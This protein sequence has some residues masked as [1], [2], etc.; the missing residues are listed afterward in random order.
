[1]YSD[2]S[3]LMSVYYKEKPEY[4][5]QSIDSMLNQI[6]PP[7][8]FVIVQDGTLTN[9]LESI[10]SSYETKYPNIFT[11]I[12]REENKGLGFSL[13]EGLKACRNE[14]VARM[15]SDDISRERR[16][17][18]QLNR[19]NQNQDL[20]ILGTQILEFE[21]TIDNIVSQRIVPTEYRDIIKFSHRRS[22]FNHPTVMYKKSI[23]LE[24]GGY[25]EVNRKEDL[26]LFVSIV[27]K[28]YH[29]EN[30]SK[31]LL[32]Y[33]VDKNNL[34]RRKTW[35]NCKEYIQ[36]MFSFYKDKVIGLDDLTYV[37]AGQLI[38]FLFPIKLTQILSNK[39]LRKNK[40]D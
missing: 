34:K 3:V 19:F 12:K 39:L 25:P 18:Y 32:Y 31:S 40:G 33:R 35:V 27:N 17:E 4:L 1:M 13:N 15:D 14:L 29:C 36:I 11:V 5:V 8:Q 30:L 26:K 7:E 2:Y 16:C 9:E 6:L 21:G 10:I 23:I 28:E 37:V 24:N 20:V 38:F 22:P